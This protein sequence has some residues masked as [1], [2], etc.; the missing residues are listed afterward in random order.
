MG[1][2]FL[3]II[4]FGPFFVFLTAFQYILSKTANNSNSK[5]VFFIAFIIRT[6]IYLNMI[7]RDNNSEFFLF[8]DF[9]FT[10]VFSFIFRFIGVS[11]STNQTVSLNTLNIRNCPKC[12]AIINNGDK[13]CSECGNSL[14]QIGEPATIEALYQK[15]EKEII[16]E[17]IK[18]CANKNNYN[19]NATIPEMKKRKIILT[20]ICGL[21]SF[22][23]TSLIFFHISFLIILLDIINIIVY[24]IVIKNF[25]TMKY[26]I[27]EIKSRPDEDIEYVVSNVLSNASTFKYSSIIY[28]SIMLISIIVPLIIFSKPH[29]FYEYTKDGYYLRFY[30]TSLKAEEH[31]TIPENYKG[32][33]VIGIRGNVF[34]NLKSL[35]KVTLPDTMEVIRGHAFDG[36]YSLV[37]INLPANLTYLGGGAFK[38]CYKLKDITLPESL[39]EIHGNTFEDTAIEYIEIPDTVIDIGGSAFK[40][41][42]YLKTVKLPNNITEI[43]GNTFENCVRLE[44]ID[45]PDSVTR[46]GGHAF[47]NNSNL[48]NVTFTENSKLEEIGSSAFRLCEKLRYISLPK[49]AVMINERAFK[50]SPTKI[51]YFGEIMYGTLIDESNYANESFGY[52]HIGEEHIIGEYIKSAICH[53]DKLILTNINVNLNKVVFTIDYISDNET[54][55]FTIDSEVPYAYINENLAIE[56]DS[57]YAATNSNSLS[58]NVYYN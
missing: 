22:I 10:F 54:K 43:H 55:T 49:S 13:F 57:K 28:T 3:N 16:E 42:S 5:K 25:N 36:D 6:F 56:I 33:K 47:Y 11:N 9:I 14:T 1:D 29:Y 52:L 12:N 37:S 2:S 24:F 27:K 45:I 35:K 19:I 53:N 39:T 30:T 21:I 4:V 58:F 26:L 23:L 7:F 48:S 50:E 18:E 17:L 41:C 44:S 8:F 20:A 38:N 31:I 51:Y 40:N 34:K 32:K 15:S 46:I